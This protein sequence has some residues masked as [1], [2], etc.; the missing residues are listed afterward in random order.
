VTD[1]LTNDF[2]LIFAKPLG[3]GIL[4]IDLFDRNFAL[5]EEQ[6]LLITVR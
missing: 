2:V 3:L 5:I 4:D 1:L 6:I